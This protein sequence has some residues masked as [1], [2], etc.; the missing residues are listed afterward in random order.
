MSF[1]S[2]AEARTMILR[3]K[4]SLST[5]VQGG[6]PLSNLTLSEHFNAGE[7]SQLLK[8]PNCAGFRV[9]LGMD[10]SMAIKLVMVGTDADGADLL[11]QGALIVDKGSRCPPECPPD[12]SINS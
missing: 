9:Y 6:F 1:I 3:Y 11:P 12:S 4:D 2:P 5:I 10:D 7:V 8:Q